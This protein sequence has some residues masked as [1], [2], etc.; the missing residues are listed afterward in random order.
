MFHDGSD[1]MRMHNAYSVVYNEMVFDVLKRRFGEGEAVVFARAASAGGQR[2]VSRAS[3]PA[4]AAVMDGSA[5][6]PGGEWRL[7]LR[8]RCVG[9]A[10]HGFRVASTGVGIASRRSRR[11][12]SRSAGPSA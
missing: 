1:P 10:A 8:I 5:Q 7:R 3:S 11:W 2:C 6:V 12:R 4:R 9:W